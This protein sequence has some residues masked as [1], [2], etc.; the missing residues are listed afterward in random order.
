MTKSLAERLL[1]EIS[2]L[3]HDATN[4]DGLAQGPED[5]GIVEEFLI[6]CGRIGYTGPEILVAVEL[7][8]YLVQW[9]MELDENFE[10]SQLGDLKQRALITNLMISRNFEVLQSKLNM[11]RHTIS[12]SMFEEANTLLE[13]NKIVRNNLSRAIAG[14]DRKYSGGGGLL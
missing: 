13:N 2:M 11:C 7:R 6:N 12:D 8:E 14:S 1:S 9:A 4:L 5:I 3:R 10:I